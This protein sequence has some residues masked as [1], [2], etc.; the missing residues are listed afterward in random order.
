MKTISVNVFNA[1]VPCSCHCKYCLLSYE[2]K[3]EGTDFLA[4]IS[5]SKEFKIWLSKNHPEVNF[6]YYFGYSMDTPYLIDSMDEIANLNS[7]S[8]KF[9]QFNGLKLRDDKELDSFLINLKNKGLE[10]ID[11]TFY[12]LENTHDNFA[13][14]KNDFAY[15]IRIIECANKIGINSEVGIPVMKNNLNEIDALIDLLKPMVKKIFLFVPHC[16]GKGVTLENQKID[17]NVYNQLSDDS[18]AYFNRSKYKTQFEWLNEEN[19]EP[20]GRILTLSLNPNNINNRNFEE[21]YASLE[22][23]DE[24]FYSNFPSFNELLKM[25]YDKND[26]R[27]Y[28]KKDIYAHLRR[29]HIVNNDLKISDIDERYS[30]SLRV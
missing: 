17:I 15:L 21:I 8:P 9:M 2:R 24:D 3:L 28:S 25:Y 14:R 10:L 4:G 23:M 7:N 13:E 18:K 26:Q 30:Y 12:G 22:K 20:T 11:L 5:F 16:G 6:M 29:M 27:L 19:K 1:C